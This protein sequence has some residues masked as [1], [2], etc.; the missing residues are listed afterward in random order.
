MLQNN[1]RIWAPQ[2]GMY[3]PI[4]AQLKGP[5]VVQSFLLL[6][7]FAGLYE[8]VHDLALAYD[9]LVQFEIQL[10]SDVFFHIERQ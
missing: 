4:T 3:R 9:F 2:L 7:K 6:Q 10:R 5:E 8:N 1:L